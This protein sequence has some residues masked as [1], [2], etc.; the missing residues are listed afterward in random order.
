M[1]EFVREEMAKGRMC[2]KPIGQRLPGQGNVSLAVFNQWYQNYTKY[3]SET[4]TDNILI[5]FCF[6]NYVH[7]AVYQGLVVRSC[8]GVT[9][10]C[11]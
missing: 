4:K 1:L 6:C 5:S 8:I 2:N 3:T 11:T 7:N 9:E 10:N